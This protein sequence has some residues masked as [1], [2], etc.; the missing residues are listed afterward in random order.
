[1][2]KLNVKK[3]TSA[4]DRKLPIFAE[5]DE[6]ADQIR[7]RAFRLFKSRGFD[8]GQALDD[9]LIAERQICW[10]AAELL[11]DDDEFEI[12]VALAGFDD[13]EIEVTAAPREIIVKAAHEPDD[14]KEADVSVMH[15][16]DFCSNKVFRRIGLPSG[17]DVKKVEA[18]FKNG[19]LSIG[20]PKT[21]ESKEKPKHIEISSAA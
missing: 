18:R 5:F 10:P 8:D 1:M 19:L 9:W 17:I 20:A 15:F 13:D 12:H 3:V 4:E 14:R 21:V 2:S 11:E 7:A 6:I 16:S